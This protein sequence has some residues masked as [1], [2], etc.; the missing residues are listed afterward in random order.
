[1]PVA[2]ATYSEWWWPPSPTIFRTIPAGYSS[3]EQVVRAEIDPGPGAPYLFAHEFT[4][5]GGE[6]GYLGL[7]TSGEGTADGRSALFAIRNAVGGHGA[8]S[9]F[10]ADGG[11]LATCRVPYPWEGGRSYRLRVSAGESGWWSAS[12]RDEA[13]GQE[14]AVG[15]IQVPPEWRRLAG[16]SVSRTEYRGPP[17]ARCEDLHPV[18]VVFS[19]PT[20][21]DGSVRPQREVSR[22]GA[23]TCEG[24]SVEPVPGGI[25]HVIGG[26]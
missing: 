15:G 16:W 24:S 4:F 11:R 17:L 10:T 23:G 1:V 9:A 12:L 8:A 14:T 21:D 5:V 20:A 26:L 7:T 3:F 6:A 25:R 22:L 2:R 18:Q 13:T 19:E